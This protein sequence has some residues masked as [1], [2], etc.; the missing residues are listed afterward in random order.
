MVQMVISIKVEGKLLSGG[1]NATFGY[2]EPVVNWK[3]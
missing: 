2:R 1:A 3:N